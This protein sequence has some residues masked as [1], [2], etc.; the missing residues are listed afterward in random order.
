MQAAMKNAAAA[1]MERN[2]QYAE[3]LEIRKAL[4]EEERDAAV[5][6]AEERIQ[7]GISSAEELLSI[8]AYYDQEIISAEEESAAREIEAQERKAEEIKAINREM[9]S[10]ILS[11]AS[12]FSSAIGDVY[13]SITERRLKAIDEETEA[14]LEALGLQ[15]DTETEK[16]RKEYEEA[17][18]NGDMELAAEKERELQRQQI[19]EEAEERKKKLQM[20]QAKR[21]KAIALFQATISTL[22]SVIGYMADPG[23]WAGIAMSA[24]AAA[25]GAAQIAAIAA[26]PLPSYA[27]GAVDISEDQIA[28]LH[29]GELVVPKT[30]AEGIRDGDISIGGADSRVD[31]TIINYTGAKASVS[32]SSEA[33]TEKLRIVIGDAISSEIARGRFDAP[34]TQRYQITRR[35]PRG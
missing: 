21:E 12:R 6:A 35:N 24:M 20:E 18:K 27:V 26:E 31:V 15:E 3:A 19:E 13:S 25:T 5:K 9:F 29:Q 4:I 22:S 11:F 32:R 34:L 14:A 17:V 10:S 30:F 8:N 2:G 33:D 23:G 7:A 1:E 28:Q 16:L